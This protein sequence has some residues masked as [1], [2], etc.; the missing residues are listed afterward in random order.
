MRFFPSSRPPWPTEIRL[1]WSPKRRIRIAAVLS[2]LLWIAGIALGA[3]LFKSFLLSLE[4]I[5]LFWVCA[6]GCLFLLAISVS[7]ALGVTRWI[8]EEKPLA[9]EEDHLK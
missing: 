9:K 3:S 4:E 1:I 5:R 7:I 2:I 6:G 8:P